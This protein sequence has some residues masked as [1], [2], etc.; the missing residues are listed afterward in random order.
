MRTRLREQLKEIEED[1]GL[2]GL[3]DLAMK[4]AGYVNP[5]IAAAN[6]YKVKDKA[7]GLIE[8]LRKKG[9]KFTGEKYPRSNQKTKPKPEKKGIIQWH[10]EKI[11]AF[12][13]KQQSPK[14][15]PK[16]SPKPEPKSKPSPKPS[17]KP[18]P[19]GGFTQAHVIG[20]TALA[21]ALGLGA[22]HLYKKYKKRKEKK[23]FNFN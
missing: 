16:P 14:P 2:G 22:R 3:G 18:E 15:I 21:A 4:G 17:P 12:N 23:K 5:V 9:D 7:S 8:W 13:K 10:K 11:K 19:K 6:T 1:F 20:G